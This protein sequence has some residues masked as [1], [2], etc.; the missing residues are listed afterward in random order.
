MMKALSVAGV[1]VALA[2]APS[3]LET[4]NAWEEKPE[5]RGAIV[6][7]YLTIAALLFLGWRNV[8]SG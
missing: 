8:R 4:L 7:G 6:A 2:V 3:F 5:R 1:V